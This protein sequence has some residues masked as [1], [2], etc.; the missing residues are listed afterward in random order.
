MAKVIAKLKV[1]PVSPE[2]DRER[3]KERIKEAVE[4]MGVRCLNILEEP[5]AFGLYAIYVLV[6]MEEKEGGTE[7]LEKEL[8]GLEDVESVEVVE[9]SLA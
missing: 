4:N 9:V 2:V 7:P 5:L 6:E 3:L 8:S 1:M